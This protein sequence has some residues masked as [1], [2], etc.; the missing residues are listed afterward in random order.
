M[1]IT[2]TIGDSAI[3]HPIITFKVKLD[4]RLKEQLGPNTNARVGDVLHPDRHDNS[5]DRAITNQA[6]HQAQF[7]SWLS[8]KLA[9]ENINQADE[10]T[11]VA[12]GM[13]AIHLKQQY[14]D[15]EFPLLEQVSYTFASE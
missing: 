9:G 14:V 12:Y 1:A 6:Q 4:R 2:I 15:V 3:K 8:G 5:Q 7:I 10:V 13:K 11:I